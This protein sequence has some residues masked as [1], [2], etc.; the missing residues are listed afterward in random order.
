MDQ[1]KHEACLLLGSN[2]EPEKNIVQAVVHLQRL[3][4]VLQVSSAWQS[5]AMGSSGPD[6]LNAALLVTTPLDA[7]ALKAQGL[8]EKDAQFTSVDPLLKHLTDLLD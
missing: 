7:D 8:L 4:T 3:L 1:E 2:I 6:F 5:D